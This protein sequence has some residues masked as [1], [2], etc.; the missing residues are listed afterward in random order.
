MRGRRA[1]LPTS[2]IVMF[3]RSGATSSN[4]PYIFLKPAMPAGRERPDRAGADRVDPDPVRAEVGGE[5]ADGR[6]ERRLRDAH[7]VVVRDDL[8]GAVVG[9]RHDRRTRAGG[10]AGRRGSARPASRRRRR[11]RAR[12]RRAT[13]RRTPPSRSSRFANARAWTRMSRWSVVSPQRLKTRSMSASDWTSQGSTKV[14]PIESASG[15]TRL[16]MRLSIDEKPT[17]APSAWSAWAMPHAIEWS[18]ATPKMSA[19]LP[20]EQTH[21]APSA[22]DRLP[23]CPRPPHPTTDLTRGAARRAGA[24]PRSRRRHRR[25]RDGRSGGGRCHRRSRAAGRA[26]TGSSRTPRP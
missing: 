15:R 16:S 14:E 5:V 4:A 24:A 25:C 22:S 18:L 12:S 13:C 3:E 21:P 10:R 17:S 20:V 23:S 9:Q 1:V 2:S 6:L 7:H 8:L 11:A 26:R 19:F